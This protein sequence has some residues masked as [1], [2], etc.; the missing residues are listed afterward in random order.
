MSQKGVVAIVEVNILW[1]I[2]RFWVSP[3]FEL[4]KMD[5]IFCH[6]VFKLLLNNRTVTQETIAF[7]LMS[8]CGIPYQNGTNC[9]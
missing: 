6:K 7:A 2:L 8:L 3:L 1:K 4:K 5:T 9:L